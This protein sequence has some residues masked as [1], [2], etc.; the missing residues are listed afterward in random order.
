MTVGCREIKI[1]SLNIFELE[2]KRKLVRGIQTHDVRRIS[3]FIFI[4][5]IKIFWTKNRKLVILKKK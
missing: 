2:N 1:R 3:I 5:K 4:I